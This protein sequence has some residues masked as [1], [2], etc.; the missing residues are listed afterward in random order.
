[1]WK[2]FSKSDHVEIGKTP[3]LDFS[4]NIFL[5]YFAIQPLLKNNRAYEILFWS[6]VNWSTDSQIWG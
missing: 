5:D 1:M 4:L 6:Q 2:S 3:I